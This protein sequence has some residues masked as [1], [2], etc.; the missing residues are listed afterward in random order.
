VDRLFDRL[1]ELLRSTLTDSDMRDE[2]LDEELSEAWEELEGYMSGQEDPGPNRRGPS[3][4]SRRH[5]TGAYGSGGFSTFE[6]DEL[7]KDFA[8]LEIPFGAPLSEVR[9]AYRRLMRTYHPD[10]H[11]SNPEKARIATEITQRLNQSFRRILEY[12][13]QSSKHHAS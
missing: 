5:R 3:G 6:A 7:R 4:G 2:P 13:G 12:Y 10:R 9:A 1:G 11:A 8:N